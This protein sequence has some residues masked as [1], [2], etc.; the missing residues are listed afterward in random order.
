MKWRDTGA[1]SEW[2]WGQGEGGK[3]GGISIFPSIFPMKYETN[4]L[5]DGEKCERCLK[6]GGEKE[7]IKRFL[8]VLKDLMG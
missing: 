8:T 5:A 3:L 7:V 4:L 6:Y 2:R 1:E